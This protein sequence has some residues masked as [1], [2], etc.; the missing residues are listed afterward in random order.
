MQNIIARTLCFGMLLTSAAGLA[1]DD[2]NILKNLDV[3]QFEVAA[4]PQIAPNGSAIAYV[5]R[6][7]DI[8]S[9]RPVSNVWIVKADGSDHRPLLSGSESYSSPRWSPSGDRLAF[10]T[11]VEGRGAQLHVRYMDTGQVALLT[12]IRGG[13][14]GISWS[15]DG[16]QLAFSRFVEDSAPPLA[17]PPG[18]PK[19]AEWAPPVRVIDRMPYRS[20]GGG[21]LSTGR[22][23]IFVVSAE[24]GTPRQLTSGDY[25]H[26]GFLSWSPDGDRILFAATR[27]EDAEHDP[28]E[29]DIWSVN[30]ADGELTQLTDRD[31]PD[32]GATYSPDGSK[33]AYLGFDDKKL[34]YHSTNVYVM[35]A[36]GSDR[37]NLT[38]E[39]DRQIDDVQWAGSS[40]SFYVQYDDRGKTHVA[41][42][43]MSG[44]IESI[45]DTLGGAILG[46]PYT[47]G[48]FSTANNG[49][50]AFTA[51]TPYRPAD[52][53]YGRGKRAP[54]KLTNLNDDALAHKTLADIEEIVW[55]SSADGLEVQGWIATPPNFDPQ[56]KYPLILEIHGG[57]FAAYGPQFSPEVQLFAAAGYVVLYT[58]PRGSTSYG[59]AFANEI[60][61]NYPGQDYDDLMSGVDAVIERGYV[62]TDQLYVTGGSGGGVLTA[63]I[64]G[65][66]DRFRAA[67]VA[68]PVINWLS[69]A[70]TADG[71][72][73]FTRYWFADMPWDNPEAYWA[74][75]P[76]SLVG[77]VTTPTALLTG[78]ADYRTPISESEQYY[79]AL[80][81]RKVDT[82]LIRVPEASHG[83]AARPSH[84]IAKVD[85]IL[86]WFKRYAENRD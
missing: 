65:K 16:S 43:S 83:I 38:E 35:D 47:S 75:S 49:A 59:D 5:R 41:S 31:G 54:R 12:N 67:V 8:M 63:W 84:L 11:N 48:S 46:R 13:P 27:K 9:D 36:D 7:M 45:T 34:G 52:V 32:F 37:R 33:I 70:L 2:A 53:G 61:H 22:N 21:Y 1:D 56:E 30:V 77:N 55:S 69:F 57:P 26:G 85:N 23:H 6:S 74:R 15:P 39:F 50:F 78:E 71:T 76:L 73:F 25:N 79:Q 20:D 86:A 66:T 80:M 58:N 42:L 60:H 10:V 81:L 4:D 14:R 40:K 51:G 68:K 82:A 3:F 44:A 64:V 72:H 17:K 29:A 24:G 19:D 62:D 18:A 28:V